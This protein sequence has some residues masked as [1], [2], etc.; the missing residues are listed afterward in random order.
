MEQQI[1]SRHLNLD[2]FVHADWLHS[3][4]P[5][6]RSHAAL[7]VAILGLQSAAAAAIAAASPVQLRSLQSLVIAK[8]A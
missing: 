1:Q 7:Q 6:D 4:Q 5:L 3:N 8:A 2:R